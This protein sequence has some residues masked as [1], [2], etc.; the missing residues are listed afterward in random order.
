MT[1][2]ARLA[3][4][5]AIVL[6]ALVAT[7]Y[8]LGAWQLV[9]IAR[10]PVLPAMD[11]T[12]SAQRGLTV[13]F[14]DV[15]LAN[16][17]GGTPEQAKAFDDFCRDLYWRSEKLSDERL[18]LEFMRAIATYEN[19]HS[20][21][22]D[23]RLRRVGLRVHWFSDGLYVVKA[24]PGLEAMVGAKVVAI[25]NSDPADLL[26]RFQSRLPG[27]PGWQRYR[28]EWFLTSPSVMVA[29][30]NSRDDTSLLIEYETSDGALQTL[31]VN[32]EP[33]IPG[34]DAF[35][36]WR[37]V[38]PGDESFGTRGWSRAG[39]RMAAKPLYLRDL[40]KPFAH[41]WVENLDAVYV[42]LHGSN[43]TREIDLPSFLDESVEEV[44]ARK[45]KNAIVDL[46][47]DWGGD[48]VLTRTFPSKLAAAL[49]ED[50]R[51]AV[52][53]GPNTF[54][55]GLILAAR[56]KDALGPRM[57]VVG[58]PVGDRLEFWA[59][60]LEVELP[61]TKADLY[62]PTARHDLARGCPLFDRECF[63][64]DK[65]MPAAV[66]SLAPDVPASNSF[67][68][69]MAGRDEAMERARDVLTRPARSPS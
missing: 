45:A 2:P 33:E 27:L 41:A 44:R 49:P 61:R 19:A 3:W 8:A 7:L 13:W 12:L 17:R 26:K 62:L 64:L 11:A 14:R 68:D 20:T 16:E 46:R 69:Y 63:I 51:V 56:L 34:G 24:R 4:G 47:F 28:S 29:L 6:A 40:P 42:R 9:R 60:G 48:Y 50:G 23:P 67:A 30:G 15:V 37:H 39:D 10:G 54:S 22:I 58:E 38:L 52:I 1:R 32:A 57:I 36:E 53:T 43:S 31:A 55:A 65:L 25:E 66:K 5:A 35:R 21:I 59:E 18:T